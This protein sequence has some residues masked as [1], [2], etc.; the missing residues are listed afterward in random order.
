M[1]GFL[2]IERKSKGNKTVGDRSLIPM[3]R[4]DETASLNFAID[5]TANQ[6]GVTYRLPIT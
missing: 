6:N 4:S 5:L 2:E 3:S 1:C